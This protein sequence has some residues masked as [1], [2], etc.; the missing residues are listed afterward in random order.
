MRLTLLFILSGLLSLS[1]GQTVKWHATVQVKY[2]GSDAFESQIKSYIS[3]ELRALGDVDQTDT[4]PDY[5]ITSFS[6]ESKTGGRVIGY[7]LHVTVELPV[8]LEFLHSL[9]KPAEDV[10]IVLDQ[11]LS[12]YGRLE[13]S[14]MYTWPDRDFDELA[15][16]IV[17]GDVDGAVFEE[18]RKLWRRMEDIR[19]SQKK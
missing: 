15:K 4:K 8:D 11:Y 19:K 18:A 3:R 7:A 17:S 10:G 14:R 12:E 2:A 9:V 5:I 1:F 16:R 13:K 6:M